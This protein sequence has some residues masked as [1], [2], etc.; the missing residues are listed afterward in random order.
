VVLASYSDGGR[1]RYGCKE[2][3]LI[4]SQ[5]MISKIGYSCLFTGD[6]ALDEQWWS[7]VHVYTEGRLNRQIAE[8]RR[9]RTGRRSEERSEGKVRR[10]TSG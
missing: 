1:K 2:A 6:G 5:F 3:C 9:E 10:I 4:L 8:K 7:Q